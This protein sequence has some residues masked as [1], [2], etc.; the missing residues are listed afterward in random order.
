MIPDNNLPNFIADSEN[1]ES[2]SSCRMNFVRNG[3]V[4]SLIEQ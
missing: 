4:D 1:H 2:C 3:I